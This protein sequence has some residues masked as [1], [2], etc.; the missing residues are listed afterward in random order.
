M[1]RRTVVASLC[2]TAVWAPARAQ[3]VATS[4]VKLPQDIVYKGF[5]RAPQHVT[6]FGDSSQAGLYVDHL[7]RA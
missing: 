3:T 2:T 5:P 4:V 1:N 6:L 7:R